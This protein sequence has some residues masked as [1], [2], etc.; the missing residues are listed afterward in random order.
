MIVPFLVIAIRILVPF[1][2]PRWPFWGMLLAAAADAS[3]VIILDKFGWGIL[4][5]RG[6]YH[7]LD[8][9]FDI[10][11]LSFA[12]YTT[13][14]WENALLRRTALA[15]FFWRL[16][17]VIVFE[18]TQ[19]RQIFF[20]APNIF[21]N[22]YLIVSGLRLFFPASHINNLKRF[23]LVLLIAAL[24]KIIQEYIMHYLEF[25][26]WVFFRSYFFFWLY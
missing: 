7:E 16:A 2:I 13:L 20:F 12:A 5:G 3:D 14:Q 18:I 6:I 26:T 11:Y 4:E 21:E 25:P 8:K 24:P 22:F 9:F 23:L 10:Y 1:T 17:G 15:L 19:I